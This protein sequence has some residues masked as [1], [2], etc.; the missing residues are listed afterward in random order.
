MSVTQRA[1]RTLVIIVVALLIARVMQPHFN[2]TNLAMVYVVAVVVAGLTLGLW[3]AVFTCIAGVALFDYVNIAPHFEFTLQARDYFFTF[4]VMLATAVTVSVL[5]E[6]LR[7][8]AEQARASA[9]RSRAL[10][11]LSE[12]LANDRADDDIITVLRQHLAGTFRADCVITPAG[13]AHVPSTSVRPVHRPVGRQEIQLPLRDGEARN[14]DI[15]LRAGN[16]NWDDEDGSL[17]RAMARLAEQAL[18]RNALRRQVQAAAIR[19]Q[20]ESLRSSI[21]GAVSHDLRTPLAAIIGASSTLLESGG[22][23]V[24]G[25]RL[26]LRQVIFDEAVH[27]QRMVE[28]LLD[29]ARIRSGDV[30]SRMAWH[31]PEEI[32]ASTL[33]ACRRRGL[34]AQLHVDVPNDLPL[35]RCDATLLERVLSNLIEN[36]FKHSPAGA[37]VTLAARVDGNALVVTVSDNG[38][39][40]PQALREQ[41]F[42]PFFR[43]GDKAGTGLGLTIC[44]GIVEAHGGSIRLDEVPGG[45]T[46][47]RFTIPLPAES[48]CLPQDL[49]SAGDE[50]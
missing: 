50:R 44:R 1:M 46:A 24:D 47:A 13:D 29:L 42:D 27:M 4:L 32:V 39:G 34:A 25:V 26:Q 8:H 23:L 9:A 30:R 2:E 49:A 28:D 38:P 36:A 18:A 6:R 21:L 31:A 10:F 5:A 19:V 45:G 7:L 12:A 20:E 37:A 14:F 41:V 35:I 40:I 16:G 43:H 15:S 11:A 33:V 17:L 3:P 22:T 48:P